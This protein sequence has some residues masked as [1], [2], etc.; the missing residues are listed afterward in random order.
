LEFAKKTSD[1]DGK[2]TLSKK[3]CLKLLRTAMTFLLRFKG[4]LMKKALPPELQNSNKTRA[5]TAGGVARSGADGL[6]DE[7]S[8]Q[9]NEK[10]FR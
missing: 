9:V 4:W 2:Q 1:T 5:F 6:C 3:R 10:G 8:V 7:T